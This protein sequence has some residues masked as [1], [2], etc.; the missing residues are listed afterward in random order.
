MG[1]RTILKFPRIFGLLPGE[2]DAGASAEVD[3]IESREP[4]DKGKPITRRK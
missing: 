4:T 2:D 3:F 1:D